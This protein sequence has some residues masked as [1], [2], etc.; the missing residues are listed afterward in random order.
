MS[1]WPDPTY[2]GFNGPPDPDTQLGYL[3]AAAG[4]LDSAETARSTDT[5]EADRAMWGAARLAEL[6]IAMA[7]ACGEHRIYE[8]LRK[9]TVNAPDWPA[10]LN[11]TEAMAKRLGEQLQADDEAHQ[12]VTI[13]PGVD[14]E[15]EA[16]GELWTDDGQRFAYAVHQLNG[17]G[18]Y[19]PQRWLIVEHY[20]QVLRWQNSLE[21]KSSL[22]TWEGLDGKIGWS[23]AT[24]LRR[25]TAEERAVFY[26]PEPDPQPAI[27]ELHER[28]TT[29][30]P[31]GPVRFDATVEAFSD[32]ALIVMREAVSREQ[33]RRIAGPG[34]AAAKPWRSPGG[35]GQWNG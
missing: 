11:D 21:P 20:A 12:A 33:A 2:F 24:P 6:N 29:I 23:D 27:E 25:P 15:P 10:A 30:P 19:Y 1:D 3:R 16:E 18:V 32:E 5:P 31:E 8:L 22:E 26:G 17:P 4:W 14:P 35:A 13:R 7:R 34:M 28:T 9:V